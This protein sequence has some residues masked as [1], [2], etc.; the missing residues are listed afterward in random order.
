MAGFVEGNYRPDVDGL[1][2]L[3]VVPVIL[4]HFRLTHLAPGGFVGVDIFF[5]ISGFLITKI[6]HDKNQDGGYRIADFYGRRAKRILPALFVMLLFCILCT[7]ITGFPGDVASISR[8]VIGSVMSISNLLFYFSSGYFD[9]KMAHNPLLHT[10]SLSVEEQFYVFFP[11]L[12][13][14]LKRSTHR[15][16]V[17]VISCIAG[18]SFLWAAEMVRTNPAAAFYLVPSRAWELMVGALMAI[19]AFPTIS[20]PVVSEFAALLG[21]SIIF[22]S[23][24]L[25]NSLTPFPGPAALAPCL[26][27]A[28]II[29]AGVGRKTY[30]SKLL[31]SSPLRFVGMISYSLYLWHWPVYVI[32][33]DAIHIP[34]TVDKIGLMAACI[35]ISWLSFRFVEKPFR[36]AKF[37]GGSSGTLKLAG[38]AA[39]AMCIAAVSASVASAT[40]FPVPGNV[41]RVLSF[42]NYD[43]GKVMRDGRC[44]LTSAANDYSL[45]DVK[46]CLATRHGVKNVLLLGDSHAAEL[47][48]GFSENRPDINF[49]Q[50]SAS[51]CKPVLGTT[52]AVRCTELMHF[53]FNEFLPL[54]RLDMIVLS[55]Q[56][57]ELDAHRAAESARFLT[58]YADSVVILGPTV[59][60]DQLFPRLLAKG[61]YLN[62]LNIVERHIRPEQRVIDRSFHDSVGGMNIRYVSAYNS[63][64]S[65]VCRIW[66]DGQI[67]M[68]FDDNHLTEMGAR[69]LAKE[70][71][72]QI[73]PPKIKTE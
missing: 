52:G 36:R 20:R 69:I 37:S 13:F 51:G 17:L 44:F 46:S 34:G 2:A 67:P 71:D 29:H 28:L 5:V 22:A 1:R 61:L 25:T 18:A 26:G 16:R 21:I 15:V 12:M 19:E 50:A 49:L 62:N 39:A 64:C 48:S 27:A 45:F 9:A 57:N 23:I 31:G 72:A 68:Y 73:F 47:W 54:H 32:Y 6:L 11:I 60:F 43:A 42:S 66:A 7:F 40:L 8:S 53:M 33:S 65:P 55:A 70:I 38:A 35:F 59:E 30:V 10:W 58:R 3:A 24:R 4:Y 56:W 14:L 63:L 41:A